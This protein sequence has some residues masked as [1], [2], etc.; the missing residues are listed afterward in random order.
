MTQKPYQ[1]AI[2]RMEEKLGVGSGSRSKQDD[3]K[4]KQS[5]QDGVTK[6]ILAFIWDSLDPLRRF[7]LEKD[8][9]EINGDLGKLTNVIST[10]FQI[11]P[12]HKIRLEQRLK[13]YE[14]ALYA[15]LLK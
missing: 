8:I 6:E 2:E 3:E 11:I 10:Y 7:A 14:V 1:R 12:N 4:I 5:I 13:T 9:D 15:K